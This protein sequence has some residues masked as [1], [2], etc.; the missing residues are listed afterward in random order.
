M[1]D[2]H[3]TYYNKL[4]SYLHHRSKRLRRLYLFGIYITRDFV[5]EKKITIPAKL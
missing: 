2:V 1:G 4:R 5:R 3:Y